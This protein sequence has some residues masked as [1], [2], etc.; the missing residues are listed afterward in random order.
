MIK[1]KELS[2]EDKKV[3]DEYIKNPSDIHDKERQN[4]SDKIKQEE[5]YKFDLHGYSLDE[6]N[7]KARELMEHCVKN[8][9]KEL[10]LITGKGLHSAID[11]DIYVSK[12]LGKLKYSVPEFIKTH[13]E[14]S[15]FVVSIKDAEKQDGGEG[16]LIIKLK[17]L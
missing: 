2:I 5:R 4:I 7:K 3:W 9:F 16:A 10:L 14:L 15:K 8:K 12:D 13:P 1:K 6:A 17:N 11:E